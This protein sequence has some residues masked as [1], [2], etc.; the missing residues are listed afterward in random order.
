MSHARRRRSIAGV[1]WPLGWSVL[2]IVSGVL[3]YVVLVLVGA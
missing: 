1:L 2:L 3:T